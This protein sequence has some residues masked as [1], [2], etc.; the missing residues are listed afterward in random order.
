MRTGISI[1]LGDADRHRLEAIA[2][3]RNSPQK[4]VWRAHLELLAERRRG[5]LRQAHTP[6]VEAWRVPL[7]RRTPDRHQPPRRRAQRQPPA[8]RVARRPGRHHRRTFPR[9]PSVPEGSK[10]WS[11]ST[12]VLDDGSPQPHSL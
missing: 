3:D 9:V 1:T 8:L 12:R 11:Q 4:H 7:R 2:A 6:T 10:R 5:F